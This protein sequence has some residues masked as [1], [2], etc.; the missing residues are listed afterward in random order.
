VQRIKYYH[1]PCQNSPLNVSCFYDEV[2][3]CLCYEHGN[4]RLANCF[5]FNH[6]MTVDDFDFD[7]KT[8]EHICGEDSL[9]V[10]TTSST[11]L[12]TSTSRMSSIPFTSS[13]TSILSTTSTSSAISSST[14]SSTTSLDSSTLTTN[15]R[16]SS[17]HPWKLSFYSFILLS[18]LYIYYTQ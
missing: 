13:T 14:L 15:S 9:F 12:M 11:S 4:Q 3:M 5:E 1:L 18:C 8:I 16:M 6:H 2:H 10:T 17:V 7:N